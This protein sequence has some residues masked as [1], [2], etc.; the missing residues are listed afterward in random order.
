MPDIGQLREEYIGDGLSRDQLAPDPIEQFRRWFA[1]AQDAGV[2]EPNAMTL[3]TV[4][5]HG[6]PWQRIVLLKAY[7]EKG[8]VF[9]TN[10]ESSK[11][12]QMDGNHLVSLHF[13]WIPLSRQIA[14]TGNVE[15]VSASES[16]KYFASRPFGSK[17]GAWVSQQSQVISSR[18]VLEMKLQE[19]KEKFRNGEVPLPSFW[20]GY[21][22]QP[23]TVE[24]WQGGSNR[25]HDRFL[26][27]RG[28]GEEWEIKRLS[29]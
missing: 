19:L 12:K 24:F 16:L 1:Q 5:S 17:L 13:P 7:D 3:A 6:Q 9:Y 11:S 4:D 10:Y 14:I 29:P 8:F 22:V 27:S 23:K 25:L 28:S 2:P 20:G 15:K 26:Y 21:R 18:S